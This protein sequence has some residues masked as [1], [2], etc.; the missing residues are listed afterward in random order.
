MRLNPFALSRSG[1]SAQQLKL[2][3]LMRTSVDIDKRIKSWERRTDYAE[4]AAAK[5]RVLD[6][7]KKEGFE[8]VGEPLKEIID[9][10]TDN[11]AGVKDDIRLMNEDPFYTDAD[12]DIER[13]NNIKNDLE[14]A[15][16]I[17]LKH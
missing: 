7:L 15:L 1:K 3:E 16:D 17:L 11:L 6:A 13:L 8:V 2:D 10:L 4:L 5:L 12:P 14:S 9:E